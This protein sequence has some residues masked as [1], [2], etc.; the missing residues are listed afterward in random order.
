MEHA[1]LST[2]GLLPRRPGADYAREFVVELIRAGVLLA[3]VLDN[4]LEGVGED[5]RVGGDTGS[6]VLLEMLTGTLR[7]VIEAAG[8]A[9]VRAVTPLFDAC[10]ERTLSDLQRALEVSRSVR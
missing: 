9:P 10:V 2:A 6:E 8:E 4:L 5:E 1:H 7:P 3:E